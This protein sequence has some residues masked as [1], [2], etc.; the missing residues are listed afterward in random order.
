[1]VLTACCCTVEPAEGALTAAVLPSQLPTSAGSTVIWAHRLADGWIV[2]VRSKVSVLGPLPLP[3]HQCCYFL[4]LLPLGGDFLL[5]ISCSLRSEARLAVFSQ[6][7]DWLLS[8]IDIKLWVQKPEVRSNKY[9][10]W[11]R[12]SRYLYVTWGFIF[13]GDVL[14]FDSLHLHTYVSTFYSLH[15]RNVLVTVVFQR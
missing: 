2:V 9:K 8:L 1:M 3:H 7:N 12:F 13:N 4:P 6:I 15:W 11:G 14:L 5:C 10:Y